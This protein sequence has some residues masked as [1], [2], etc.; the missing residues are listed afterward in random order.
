[1]GTCQKIKV[2]RKE[3]ANPYSEDIQTMNVLIFV[4]C[5]FL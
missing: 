1:M 3:R 5:M 2:L 4:L